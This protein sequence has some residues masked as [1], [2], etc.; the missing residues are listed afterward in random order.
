MRLKVVGTEGKQ[1]KAE[2]KAKVKKHK[3][4]HGGGH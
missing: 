4:K 3:R 1:A 2:R